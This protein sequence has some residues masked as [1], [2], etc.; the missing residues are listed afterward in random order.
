MAI[1]N[2]A[3]RKYVAIGDPEVVE[4]R[5]KIT[6]TGQANVYLHEGDLILEALTHLLTEQRRTNQLLYMIAGSPL[7][8]D[9]NKE[10]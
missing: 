3:K 1:G 10:L 2:D 4:N 6:P 9:P 8:D 5:L 7:I